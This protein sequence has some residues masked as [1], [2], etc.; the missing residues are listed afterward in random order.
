M[1]GPFLGSVHLMRFK[2][3]AR[4][5]EEKKNLVLAGWAM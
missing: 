4:E 5:N 2:V 3:P 1:D